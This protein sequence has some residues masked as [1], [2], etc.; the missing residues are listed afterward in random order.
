MKIKEIL[1]ELNVV[2]TEEIKNEISS[3]YDGFA[4]E[5]Q[6]WFNKQFYRW[7]INNEK[8]GTRIGKGELYSHMY[9][10]DIVKQWNYYENVL[11]WFNI[12]D[13]K[14]G[15]YKWI[16][17]AM[18]NNELVVKINLNTKVQKQA[19]TILKWLFHIEG[20]VDY[21]SESRK[22]IQKL[23]RLTVPEA[24]KRSNLHVKEMEQA[25]IDRLQQDKNYK[26]V[27]KFP[28]GYSIVKL[29][30][31]DCK[32]LEGDIMQNCI[33]RRYDTGKVFGTD[34]TLFSL[35]D[36]NN[37]AHV[38]IEVVG[39]HVKY[40]KGKQNRT[41]IPKYQPYIIAFAK[42]FKLDTKTNF[43]DRYGGLRA[44]NALD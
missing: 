40:V 16:K 13:A 7:V 15:K 35:R 9:H 24:I 10:P 18:D 12:A 38:I 6:S 1:L 21:D 37:R 20:R 32:D 36:P 8:L 22:I 34:V 2:N 31:G 23:P 19:N 44:K 14:A 3:K 30:S 17:K 4:P 11:D 5:I 25:A 28:D 41:P 39:D 33:D 27:M 43:K 26:V 42:K 29:L